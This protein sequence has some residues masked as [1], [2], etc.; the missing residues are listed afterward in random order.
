M[1]RYRFEILTLK[2]GQAPLS[3]GFVKDTPSPFMPLSS[4]FQEG[5][6]MPA[7]RVYHIGE[8]GHFKQART[9]TC[10]SDQDALASAQTMIDQWYALEVWDAGRF[11]GRVGAPAAAR[12]A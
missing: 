6:T 7:Y 10:A 5:R 12:E 3:N 4:A 2:N 11:V 9:V 1:D 8:D